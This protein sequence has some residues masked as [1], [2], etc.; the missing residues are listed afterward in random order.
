MST[1]LIVVDRLSK[2]I[3]LGAL[4]ADFTVAKV[5]ELFVE[6]VVKHHGFPKS[7]IFDCDP[8]FVSTF[9]R[10]LFELSGTKLSMRSSY[11]PQTDGK[12]EVVN[13]G[14]EQ[15]IRAFVQD[16]PKTWLFFLCWDE[17]HYNS[18]FHNSLKMSPFQALYGCTPPTI[19][20]YTRALR[21]F[22]QLVT[23]LHNATNCSKP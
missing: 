2:Y 13:R 19:P 4:P 9:W 1:I 15:Y 6:I 23:F 20:R 14:L 17:F 10:G 8:V 7:I 11:H 3:Y 5:A 18:S 16:N 21:Q 12:T 22:K